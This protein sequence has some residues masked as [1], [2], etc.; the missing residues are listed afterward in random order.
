[1]GGWGVYYWPTS[2]QTPASV[3]MSERRG[4][5][6]DRQGVGG[7]LAPHWFVIYLQQI[8]ELM[9]LFLFGPVLYFHP[10][11]WGLVQSIKDD[12]DRLTRKQHI[13]PLFT[14]SR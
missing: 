5:K 9:H 12:L 2:P 1:M 3:R 13:N 8:V 10:G 6:D 14:A 4:V 7:V 11:V